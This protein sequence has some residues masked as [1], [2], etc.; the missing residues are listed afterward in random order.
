MT[1]FKKAQRS[2]VRL[3]LAM[4][5]PTGSGK[6]W[7]ALRLVK[8]L[9]GKTAFIDTENKSA[10]LYADH[11][12]F[13][14]LDL[15]PPFTTEKYID[16]IN[17]AE[18]AGY[19]NIIIDSLTHA[20][21]GEGGLLEQ[22]SLL[23]SRPGSNHWTN[24][25]P[26]DKKDLQLK[27]AF[28]HST[29]HVIATM[30]SKM[31]YSQVED[32]GKK[33]VQKMG[34]APV[35]RDGLSY[36]FTTV[37][38]IA[39]DHKCEVSKDRT[40]IFD[41]RIFQITEE[42][43]EEINAWLA[44]GKM[45]DPEPPKPSAPPPTQKMKTQEKSLPQAQNGQRAIPNRAPGANSPPVSEQNEDWGSYRTKTTP[46]KYTNRLLREIPIH[47][48]VDT[49]LKWESAKSIPTAARLDVEAM[50]KYIAQCNQEN[51][52]NQQQDD[53]QS[54]VDGSPMFDSDEPIP[55]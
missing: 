25:G 29:C 26:I 14:V 13:D 5:G 48:V 40:H 52:E 12:D 39:M 8:G 24:W 16:A 37:F 19:Q 21:A 35:Q 20:W 31:E 3:K 27:N 43:G 7:S 38:D 49:A 44:S 23:D 10:S 50:T 55:F 53:T 41:G 51:D 30:R 36:D 1:G 54:N 17:Q 47:V 42:S 6:T 18:K 33:K 46:L 32:G 4:T 28:L 11:F 22:K 2:Q 9:G 15:S 45:P 34:L